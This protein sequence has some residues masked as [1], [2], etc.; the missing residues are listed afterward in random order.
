MSAFNILHLNVNCFNCGTKN[1]LR[2]Q[3][4]FGDTWQI[5]YHLGEKIKWG[6][7]DIGIEHLKN[8]KV[9]G[10]AESVQCSTC[11]CNYA[12]EEYDIIIASDIIVQV[13]PMENFSDYSIG[14][15]HYFVIG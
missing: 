1:N 3:F 7:N 13:A 5:E 11:G 12:N 15:G 14:N 10:I 4:K 9:Y 6:G 8:V 2:I